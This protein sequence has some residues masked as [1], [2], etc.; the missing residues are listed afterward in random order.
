MNKIILFSIGI[1]LSTTSVNAGVPKSQQGDT[2]KWMRINDNYQVDTQDV[3]MKEDKLRF[4]M[5]RTA[6]G[7]EEM[8]TQQNSYWTGKV[9]IRCKAFQAKVEVAKTCGIFG[10]KCFYGEWERMFEGT[11]GYELAS[12]FCHLTGVP[13]YTPEPITT[14]WQEKITKVLSKE[15]N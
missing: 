4:W 7:N 13:G 3:E 8:S 14:E 6:T 12:N 11:I 2:A 10:R 15:S 5:R 1:A 9:R